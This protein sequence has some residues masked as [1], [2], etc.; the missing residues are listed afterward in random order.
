MSKPKRIFSWMICIFLALLMNCSGRKA[1]DL[2]EFLS[3]AELGNPG[4][5]EK[6]RKQ[7]AHKKRRIIYNNDGADLLYCCDSAN[8]QA[9]LG[10]RIK[11]LLGTQVDTLF[12]STSGP[13]GLFTHHTHIGEVFTSKAE[14]FSRN[15]T[16]GFIREGTDALRLVV[17]F[18]REN[19]IEIFWSMRMNDIH[20]SYSVWY[21][22]YMLPAIKKKHPE[23]LM[24]DKYRRPMKGAWSAVDY[25]RA[26]IRDLA[27]RFAEEICQ[28]YEVDGIEL[29]FMRTPM[30]FKVQS[31]GYECT[32][33]ERDQLTGLI[34]RIRKMT[35]NVGIR[36]G[37]PI[38]MAVRVPDS[39]AFCRAI[40]I[41]I[42][43][44][45]DEGLI[46]LLIPG[47]DSH[48]Q[49]WRASVELGYKYDVP[50]FPCLSNVPQASANVHKSLACWRGRALNALDSGADGIYV[51]NFHSPKS[52]LWR[53]I[54]DRVPVRGRDQVYTTEAYYHH[55]VDRFLTEGLKY[56]DYKG[57]SPDMPI[58]LYPGEAEDMDLFVGQEICEFAYK[59]IRLT[60]CME[61]ISALDDIQIELNGSVLRHR[62]EV[63]RCSIVFNIECQALSKGHNQVTVRWNADQPGNKKISDLYLS[64]IASKR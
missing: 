20:D 21:S 49:P 46:D 41:D 29:D 14:G 51:F 57:V 56:I 53:Q 2:L 63:N 36:R 61:Q 17:D 33:T 23:F 30:M 31:N 24:A 27:F 18:C 48:L 64:F 38:L 62:S 55:Q 47:G 6:I 4:M 15:Q 35:E 12:Y 43:T 13:F 19:Q 40:G 42:E 16:S 52:P 11:P 3:P 5:L 34:R 25:G 39:V 22:K 7:L 28:R 9:F 50:V 8:P 60:V 59:H 1:Q 58:V 54:G 45:L 37:V 26:E 10:S 32:D 44:W